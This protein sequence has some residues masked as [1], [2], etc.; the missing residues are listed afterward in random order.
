MLHQLMSVAA[1]ISGTWAIGGLF[2]YG[3]LKL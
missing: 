2:I 3:F 1:M